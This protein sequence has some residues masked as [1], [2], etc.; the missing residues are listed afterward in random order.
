VLSLRQDSISGL[1]QGLI[2]VFPTYGRRTFSDFRQW[3]N[4][5]IYLFLVT[6]KEEKIM[7][8]EKKGNREAKKAKADP[9]G[10]KKPKKDPKRH[11]GVM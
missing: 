10:G 2:C 11:D 4:R 8:K 6:K 7:S 5:Y 1:G 3:L 9:K